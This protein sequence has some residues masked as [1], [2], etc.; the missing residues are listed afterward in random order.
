VGFDESRGDAVNILNASFTEEAPPP[1]DDLQQPAIWEKPIFWDL[2]KLIAGAAVLIALVLAV[3]RPL[4]RA[5]IGS[6]R[7]QRVLMAPAEATQGLIAGQPAAAGPPVLNHEQQLVNARNLVTQD[8]KRV[9]QVV[10]EW[11]GQE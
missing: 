11:V 1:S 6:T 8:P 5:L 9:A 3:L 4:V 2:V 10:R 7:A